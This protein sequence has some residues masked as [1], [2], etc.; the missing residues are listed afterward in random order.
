MR[1]HTH[2]VDQINLPFDLPFVN[3][4]LETR[5]HSP[6]LDAKGRRHSP[7]SDRQERLH[8]LHNAFGV[9]HEPEIGYV[10]GEKWVEQQIGL[11]LVGGPVWLSE[12]GGD[13]PLLYA[14]FAMPSSIP[15]T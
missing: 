2:A 15:L 6:F 9:E 5:Q 12:R 13:I 3:Q 11:S 8:V 4:I 1:P 14:R 10:R 7:D